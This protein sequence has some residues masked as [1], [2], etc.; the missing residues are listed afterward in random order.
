VLDRDI[1]EKGPMLASS[2]DSLPSSGKWTAEF[3]WDGMRAL[4]VFDGRSF[5]IFSRNN[6]DVTGSFPEFQDVVFKAPIIM[7]GEIISTDEKGIPDFHMLQKRIHR[8]NNLDRLVKEYPVTYMVFDL[9]Q[10]GFEKMIH[11]PYHY[12]RRILRSQMPDHPRIQLSRDHREN[13]ERM[14]D[15]ALEKGLEGLILKKI[16]SIYTPG[17]RLPNWLK[18]KFEKTV[19]LIIGG[20]KPRRGTG[21]GIG[22]LLLGAFENGGSL[23]YVG[24][25]GTGFDMQDHLILIEALK[26]REVDECPFEKDPKI[27]EQRFVRPELV[28]EVHYMRWPSKGKIQQASFKGIRDY[29]EPREVKLHAGR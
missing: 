27:K 13:M 29:K 17:K 6:R 15:V 3:K 1:L 4:F 22:S 24:S 21:S 20:W 14:K 25:V 8:T 11:R 5:R 12:R 28:V 9:L 2:I 19:D 18:L 16:D 26:N 23:R 10:V 7:D